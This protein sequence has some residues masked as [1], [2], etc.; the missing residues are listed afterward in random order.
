MHESTY[1]AGDLMT[2]IPHN[3]N[4]KAIGQTSSET[5]INGVT[6]P[7]GYVNL[8]Q[9]CKVNPKKK[10]NDYLS[11]LN[12]LDYLIAL[13]EN[14]MAETYSPPGGRIPVSD[15]HE[16][17]SSALVFG[18]KSG[19]LIRT[20]DKIGGQGDIYSQIEIAIHA[21]QWIS[22]QLAVW[23]NRTLRLVINGEFK[24][25]TEEAKQ[26]EKE[27]QVRWEK[28]RSGT[29]VTRRTLTDSIQE[30]LNRPDTATTCPHAIIYANCTNQL[31]LALWGVT[32]VDIRCHFGLI[33]AKQLT[34][35]HL[36]AAALKALDFAEAKVIEAIDHDGATPHKNAVAIARVRRAKIDFKD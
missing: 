11:N 7:K 33:S 36:S 8:S 17:S 29:I 12:T 5:D 14:P 27:L 20:Y 1:Q 15:N 13:S 6:I 10:L 32:A 3:F 28:I 22:P 24:A 18:L 31:Y 30:W 25:L 35:D 21:A 26:A 2:I 19:L 34:R 23:A 9:M 4:D 16:G